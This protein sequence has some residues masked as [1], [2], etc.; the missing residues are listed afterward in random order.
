MRR[1][2]LFK[3]I[4]RSMYVFLY[5]LKIIEVILALSML[6]FN[7]IITS[8]VEFL[9]RFIMVSRRS[10]GGILRRIQRRRAWER[11]HQKE[12][13]EKENKS[14]DLCLNSKPIR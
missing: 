1:D 12:P 9:L 4:I 10:K 2:V 6:I 14:E 13:I 11:L 8:R 5:M 7:I 3:T